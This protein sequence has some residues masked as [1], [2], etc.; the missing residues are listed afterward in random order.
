MRSDW[1]ADLE[2]LKRLFQDQMEDTRKVW[3]KE[4]LDID[5]TVIREKVSFEEFLMDIEGSG[6]TAL[7]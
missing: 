4:M 2:E 1:K 5:T 3:M 6:T 7:T